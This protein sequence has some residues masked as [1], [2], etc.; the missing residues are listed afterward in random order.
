MSHIQ[1]LG[2]R[3]APILA[4]ATI[5]GCSQEVVRA[6]TG[7]P[8]N[9]SQTGSGSFFPGGPP[10]IL[11][12]IPDAPW[13]VTYRGTR[14]VEAHYTIAG[15]PADLVYREEVGSDGQGNF[16][17]VPLDVLVPTLANEPLFL[18]VQQARQGFF[19][20]YRDFLIRDLGLFFEN[21]TVTDL[22]TQK[23]VAG[24][25][26]E[27]FRLQRLADAT[28]Y[29]EIAVDS[30]NSLILHYK[31]FSLTGELLMQMMYESLDLAP[32]LSDLTLQGELFPTIPLDLGGDPSADLGFALQVPQLPPAGFQLQTAERLESGTDVWAK[33]I[34]G[35]GAERVIFMH[36]AQELGV[37]SSNATE[38]GVV[39]RYT[40]GPWTVVTGRINRTPIMLM[41]KV[42]ET[43]L[44]E[45]LRSLL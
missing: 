44:F 40:V 33:L 3:L 43:E 1:I 28:C 23:I 25:L 45:M 19:Y 32:D 34:Y 10:P 13:T 9:A 15:A 30:A 42:P 12:G 26:C 14:V 39:D 21:Y 20:R 22:A 18:L 16:A 2:S 27:Q 5:V 17:I 6:P 35:D 8:I 36:S 41:G 31:E 38:V 11:A 7:Q 4:L 37:Q 29:Y 24:R